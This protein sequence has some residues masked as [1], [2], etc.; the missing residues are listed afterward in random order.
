MEYLDFN[1]CTLTHRSDKYIHFEKVIF[2]KKDLKLAQ[3]GNV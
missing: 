3:D 2:N 1:L